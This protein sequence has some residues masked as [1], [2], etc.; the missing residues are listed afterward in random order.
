MKQNIKSI[1][2]VSVNGFMLDPFW[3]VSVSAGKSANETIEWFE[4]DIEENGITSFETVECIF[5][6]YDDD[7]YDDF[8]QTDTITIN[9]K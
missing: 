9:F 3:A 6:G 2:N 4:D 5:T 7:T 8:F 1:A